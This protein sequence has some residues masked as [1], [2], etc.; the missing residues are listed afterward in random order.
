MSNA[1]SHPCCNEPLNLDRRQFLKAAGVAAAAGF[2]PQFAWA[3]P[4][5]KSDAETHVLKL[6]QSLSD[7]QK[8][9]LV[10]PFEH[11]LRQKI[12]ANWHITKPIIREAFYTDDQRQIITDIVKGVTSPDGYERILKQ[13]EFDDGGLGG[14]S[15]AIF[16]NPGEGPFEFEL[17]GRHLTLRADGDSVDQAAFGGPIVYGHGEEDPKQNLFHYQ[18]KQVNEVFQAL[19]AK[20]AEAALLP[21][22]PRENAV[23]LQGSGKT[24]PGIAYKALSADQQKLVEQTLKVLLAPYRTE[25]ADEVLAILKSTGGFEQLHL[26]FYQDEDLENDRVWDVWRVEGPSLVWHFRGAPHVHAYINVGAIG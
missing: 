18:T 2:A 16:G 21:K 5:R 10:F 22:Q 20:Q 15:L 7:E 23:E 25:D 24:Y 3:A 12:S 14:Y 9:A 26:A 13:T 1:E 6:Y 17:T 8:K 4:S 19:D 11:E